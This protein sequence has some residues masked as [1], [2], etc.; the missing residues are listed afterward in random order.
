MSNDYAQEARE[1]FY[2]IARFPTCISVTDYVHVK[3]Q[4]PG[5]EAAEIFRN[6]KGYF[7]VN[8]Q[9]VV[10]ADFKITYIVATWPGSTHDPHIFRNSTLY[11]RFETG[12]K[13]VC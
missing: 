6:R 5:G 8:V 10:V 1:R 11:L 7:F 3:I 12:L 2:Q 9:T 13:M 4:S